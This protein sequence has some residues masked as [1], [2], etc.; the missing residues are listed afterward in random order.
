M[1]RKKRREGSLS[2]LLHDYQMPIQNSVG[3][4]ILNYSF[5]AGDMTFVILFSGTTDK[6]L[7]PPDK[8]IYIIKM[9]KSL[10]DPHWCS[11]F[12]AWKI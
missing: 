9:E 3:G 7:L 12:S 8:F 4:L 11:T 6:I 10:N 2:S 1:F 5:M